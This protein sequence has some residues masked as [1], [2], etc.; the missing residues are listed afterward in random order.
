MSNNGSG[1]AFMSDKDNEQYR[2]FKGSVDKPLA[3]LI[4]IP[5]EKSHKPNPPSEKGK[6]EYEK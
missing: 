4:V 2:L 6:E 5:D 3:R 1:G